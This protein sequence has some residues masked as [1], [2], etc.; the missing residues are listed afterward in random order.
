MSAINT[1]Q[2]AAFLSLSTRKVY[3]L[4]A[5]G[6]LACYRFGTAIRFEQS[7]LE[8]YKQKCRFPAITRAA[9]STNLTASSPAPGANA[10]T[11]YFRKAGRKSRPT[12][13]T[14][15]SQPAS[16]PLQLVSPGSSR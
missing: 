13:T 4:A 8:A 2:A 11:D 7:D 1:I 6:E 10:L 14:A 12:N 16:T 3:D 5:S 15:L 9:G